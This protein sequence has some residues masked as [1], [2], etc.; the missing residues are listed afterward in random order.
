MPWLS[1]LWT[2][3]SARPLIKIWRSLHLKDVSYQ[4]KLLRKPFQWHYYL[5]QNL[6]VKKFQSEA[7]LE[8]RRKSLLNLFHSNEI[9]ILFKIEINLIQITLLPR[10][11]LFHF[12]LIVITCDPICRT[13]SASLR[14]LMEYRCSPFL[15]WFNEMHGTY[16]DSH[17]SHS[18]YNIRTRRPR[19]RCILCLSSSSFLH[20]VHR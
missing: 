8:K 14:K 7:I 15:T 11:L 12:Y 3:K 13:T 16:F 20:T 17:S 18:T 6:N 5:V 10:F 1:I 4:I 2:M 19:L 9:C